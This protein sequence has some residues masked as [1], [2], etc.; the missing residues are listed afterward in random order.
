MHD[1]LAHSLSALS[2]ELE[3]AR[4]LALDRDADAD[5]IAAIGRA[6]RHAATGLGEARGAN[7]GAARRRHAGAPERLAELVAEFEVHG[8]RD[9]AR[10]RR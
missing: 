1:V 5:V 3:G 9:L 6:H 7:R 8:G 4:L 2:V 10:D